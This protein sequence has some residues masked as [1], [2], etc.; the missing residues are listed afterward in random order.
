MSVSVALEQVCQTHFWVDSGPPG[1]MFDT[2]YLQKAYNRVSA[3]KLWYCVR[4]SAEEK[5][6]LRVVQDIYEDN[7]TGVRCAVGVID[8]FKRPTLL[9]ER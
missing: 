2:P 1:L 8:G 4:S 5:K 7:E 3:E 9:V 6:Y